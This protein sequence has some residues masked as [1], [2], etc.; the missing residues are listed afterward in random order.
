MKLIKA[1]LK[2]CE[3]ENKII[4]ALSLKNKSLYDGQIKAGL[5]TEMLFSQL[6]RVTLTT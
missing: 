4:I 3:I 5:V 1:M 6:L 2:K